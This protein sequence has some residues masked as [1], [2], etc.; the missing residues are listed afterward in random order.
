MTSLGKGLGLGLVVVAAAQVSASAATQTSHPKPAV[1]HRAATLPA[2]VA[3]APQYIRDRI[4]ALGSA[5]NGQVGI[6][7][8]SIDDV[9]VTVLKDDDLYPQHSVS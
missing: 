5:F 9:L 3:R 6:A 2:P 1:A 4:D 8:M 7:V